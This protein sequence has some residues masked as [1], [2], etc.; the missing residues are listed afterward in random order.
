MQIITLVLIAAGAFSAWQAYKTLLHAGMFQIAGVDV[1]G[2]KQVSEAELR[3]ISGVF[4]GQNIF[5]A[6]LET[7]IRRARAN[8][9][10]KDVRIY[11][12]L[13]NRISMVVTERI[14]F[15]LL[16]TGAGWYVMDSDGVVIDRIVRENASAWQLPVVAVKDCRI[17]SGEQVTSEGAAEAL[18]LIS[19]IA[20]RGGWRMPEVTIQAASPETLSVLYADHEFKL[21]TGNYAEKLRRLAEIMADVKQ[22]GLEIS[23]VD[24]RP[25][26]Q[27]AVMVK[28]TGVKGQGSGV[29]KKRS[30]YL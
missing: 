12:R 25:E 2:A 15:A 11:R 6:D 5:K 28:N 17:R 3:E 30:S 10:V 20:E 13:P 8:P 18:M 1:K 21:G 14:A 7:S 24:L 27:A 26:R 29:R 19:E 9:W 23:S 4:T 22:R 16:D